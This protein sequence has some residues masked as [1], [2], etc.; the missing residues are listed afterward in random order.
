MSSVNHVII[1]GHL[2]ADPEL[3]YTTSSSKAVC[4]MRIATKNVYK[5]A[6]EQRHEDVEWHRIVAWGITAENC[7][8][9]LKKGSL[10]YVEG[11]LKTNTYEKNGQK[12]YS[13]DVV[14]EKVVFLGSA[15]GKGGTERPPQ[16]HDVPKDAPPPPADDD[17]V[18]F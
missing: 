9:Y 7:A 8:K 5:D 3:K 18:P 10:A 16:P 6:K 1:V 4:N 15:T 13:T 12:M 11:R 14:A 2:G 17:N